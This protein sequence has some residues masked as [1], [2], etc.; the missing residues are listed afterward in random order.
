MSDDAGEEFEVPFDTIRITIIHNNVLFG[1]VIIQ[2]SIINDGVEILKLPPSPLMRLRGS[3]DVKFN[4]KLF[5]TAIT[6]EEGK[7]DG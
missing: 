3:Y 2:P 7:D 1:D 4:E 6:N 5:F